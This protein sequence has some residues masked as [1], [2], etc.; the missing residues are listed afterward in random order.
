MELQR[1][2]VQFPRDKVRALVQKQPDTGPARSAQAAASRDVG[3]QPQSPRG[4]AEGG[5]VPLTATKLLSH[6]ATG[7][8]VPSVPDRHPLL[9]HGGWSSVSG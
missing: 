1:G 5:P 7:D 8:P 2:G 9:R 3:A 4:V 6:K